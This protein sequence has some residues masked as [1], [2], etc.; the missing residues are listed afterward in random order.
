MI[1]YQTSNN[2]DDHVLGDG[3]VTVDLEDDDVAGGI[4]LWSVMICYGKGGKLT[5]YENPM[6]NS[7]YLC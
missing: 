5:M 4:R 2:I 6:V 1:S 7:Q 3:V